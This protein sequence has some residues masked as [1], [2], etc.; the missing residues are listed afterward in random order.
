MKV[1]GWGSGGFREEL[2]APLSG[3]NVLWLVFGAQL[4][5]V[6]AVGM[7]EAIPSHIR[8]SDALRA[9]MRELCEL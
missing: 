2:N 8:A 1:V 7:I 6:A 5:S 3:A 9:P 4:M